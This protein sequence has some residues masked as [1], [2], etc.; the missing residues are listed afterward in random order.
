MME[1]YVWYSYGSDTTGMR[2]A[3][4]LKYKAG[5]KTPPFADF[6]LIVGWGCKPGEK[7]RPEILADKIGKR[8]IRV[9]NHI[10]ALTENRDKLRAFEKMSEAGVSI[11]GFARNGEAGT[12]QILLASVLGGLDRGELDFPLLGLNRYHKGYPVFCYTIDDIECAVARKGEKE[13]GLHY[14]RS[15]CPGTE[16]KIHIFRDTALAAERKILTENPIKSFGEHLLKKMKRR[17]AKKE[18]ELQATE[19]EVG[20]LAE[21]LAQDLL[22]G[23]NHLQRS[24]THGWAL[25]SIPLGEVPDQVLAQ[26]INAVDAVGLDM[27]AVSVVC[28][29]DIARVTGVISAPGLSEEQMALYVSSIREFAKA[30]K[31]KKAAVA[32][33]EEDEGA[34]QE[35]IARLKRKLSGLSRKKATEVLK[36]LEE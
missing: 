12:K 36:T 30:G 1:G 13:P 34:P 25:E 31:P 11:P 20:W 32:K 33:K 17:A 4:L 6:D 28:G 9:L 8:E 21:E 7:Y 18:V 14:F 10:D 19:T 26:A 35:L 23:P 22:A 16:F 3:Q 24:V 27:G 5:K 15:F 29:D 2:L